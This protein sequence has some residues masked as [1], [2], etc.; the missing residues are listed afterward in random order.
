MQNV[1]STHLTYSSKPVTACYQKV[2]LPS[3]FGQYCRHYSAEKDVGVWNEFIFP[4]KVNDLK[5]ITN[6]I[7]RNFI[8]LF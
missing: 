8:Q 2:F 4:L 1:Y 5:H 3:V 6:S 7:C